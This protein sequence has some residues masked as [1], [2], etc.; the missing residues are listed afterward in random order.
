MVL[1]IQDPEDPDA[2]DVER[3]GARRRSSAQSVRRGDPL[4]KF[5]ASV[6]SCSSGSQATPGLSD[7]GRTLLAR[8]VPLRVVAPCTPPGPP[9]LAK[10]I[11]WTPAARRTARRAAQAQTVGLVWVVRPAGR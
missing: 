7:G 11:A 10:L 6:R 2:T 8:G 3:T 5:G 4:F 1:V 9:S